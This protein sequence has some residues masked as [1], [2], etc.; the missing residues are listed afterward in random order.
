MLK[1]L[2][3]FIIVL[4]WKLFGALFMRDKGKGGIAISSHKLFGMICFLFASYIWMFGGI[5]LNYDDIMTLLSE[6]RKLPSKW[7]D[8][9]DVL[10][11]SVWI[12]LGVDVAKN[13]LDVIRHIKR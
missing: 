3:S 9:P 7:G 8:V 5:K 4:L 11:Y 12:F 13:T 10:I 6:G 2:K 1:N